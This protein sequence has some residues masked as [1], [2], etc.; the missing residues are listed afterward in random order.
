MAP[1]TANFTSHACQSIQIP[2]YGVVVEIPLDTRFNNLPTMATDSCRRRISYTRI[3]LSVA[4]I[5]FFTDRRMTLNRPCLSVPQQCV[6]PRKSNVSGLLC[7][8]R[9]RLVA[10][11]VQM[12]RCFR[13]EPTTATE[14]EFQGPSSFSVELYLPLRVEYPRFDLPRERVKAGRSPPEGLGLD[15]VARR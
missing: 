8:R 11:S 13:P 2:R 3:S 12:M 10:A 6:D 15:A 1:F 5:R 7:P 14:P 4:R 9:L